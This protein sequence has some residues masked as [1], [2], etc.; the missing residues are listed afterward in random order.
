MKSEV[1]IPAFISN[2][3]RDA[4]YLFLDLNPPRHNGVKLVC[5]GREICAPHYRMER[6]GFDYNAVEFIVGGA[7]TLRH[8]G[9]V[10]VLRPGA[11]F[12][13]GPHTPYCLEAGKGRD[14][15]KYFINFSGGS[16]AASIDKCGLANC[17]VLYVQELRWLQDLFDQM[18]NCAGLDAEAARDIGTRLLELILRR[19]EIDAWVGNNSL[20]SGRQTFSRCKA[21]IHE[22][23]LELNSVAQIADRCHLN[24]GYLARLFSRFAGERPLQVLTR[25]KTQH[26]ASLIMRGGYGVAQAGQAV[27]FSDPYHF[28]KVFKRV[29]GVSPGKMLSDQTQGL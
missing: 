4:K 22:H 5:A 16:A 24:P 2:E 1:E 18:L 29:H 10:E 14:L 23:Y 28:S 3:T 11:L 9:R 27:G 26:A 13:Y 8:K 12:A 17:Q 15:T 6:Q 7:W 20:S 21:F 19:I 25:L